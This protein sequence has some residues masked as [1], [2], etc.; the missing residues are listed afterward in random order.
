MSSRARRL[1]GALSLL[2]LLSLVAA[3][4]ASAGSPPGTPISGTSPGKVRKVGQSNPKAP[5][6]PAAIHAVGY[7]LT[8]KLAPSSTSSNATGRWDGV[9]VHTIGTVHNGQMP[10]APGCTVSGPKRG[11][12]GQSPP[13]QQGIPH[14]IKCGGAVPP[15][16]V[17]AN[18]QHWILGWKLTFSNLS[19]AVSGAQIHVTVPTGSPAV[20]AAALCG[21]C[22][23]GKFGRTML[24]D[25]QANAIVKGQASVVVSTANNPDG[26]ISGP[27]V[28]A[29]T[30]TTTTGH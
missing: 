12:P 5:T 17:P 29:S 19:S 4:L 24:T 18:G 10:S 2:A 21:S 28:K 27:I 26:E 7:R 9:L 14:T 25:D 30:G 22:T 6:Q 11:G 1:G 13:R 3:A 16:S 20:A 23:S 15:F 8:A